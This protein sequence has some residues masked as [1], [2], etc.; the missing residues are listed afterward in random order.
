MAV[1]LAEDA[2]L[3]NWAYTHWAFTYDFGFVK[4]GLAGEVLSWFIEPKSLFP[5]VRNVSLFSSVLVSAGLALHFWRPFLRQGG[6]GRL[7]Y[8]VLATTSAASLP[9]FF[10]DTGRFDHLGLLLVML[11]FA[12]VESGRVTAMTLLALC[13]LG[14]VLHEAFVVLYVPM[15]MTYWAYSGTDSMRLR[16]TQALVVLLLAGVA[17]FVVLQGRPLISYPELV[18]HLR[19]R[20]GSWIDEGSVTV[21]Y[22]GLKKGMGRSLGMLMSSRR[23]VQ[24][25]VLGVFLL[26]MCILA[27]RVARC[28]EVVATWATTKGRMAILMLAAALAP[29]CMYVV[30]VDFARWWALAITNVFLVV[31]QLMVRSGPLSR[32]VDDVLKKHRLL[33]WSILVLSVVSG[34]MGVAASPFPRLEPLLRSMLITLAHSIRG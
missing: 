3:V 26:P 24:H 2:A 32:A 6:S 8:A 23:L 4:R 17:V 29:L 11:C 18:Q 20:H 21:L 12:S 30:G 9:H 27:V 16:V 25:L 15:I 10:Y 34:P 14:I 5:V 7:A 13:S 31:A 22:A 33:M 1:V 19:D 28:D